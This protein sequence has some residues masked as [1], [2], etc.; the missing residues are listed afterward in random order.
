VPSSSGVVAPPSEHGENDDDVAVG[1]GVGG[2]SAAE[3]WRCSVKLSRDCVPARDWLMA[4]GARVR[5]VVH[6]VRAVH[7]DDVCCSFSR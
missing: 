7:L 1:L 3:Q 4:A 5:N 2:V 6:E